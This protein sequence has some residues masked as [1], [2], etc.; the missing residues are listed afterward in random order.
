MLLVSVTK[1]YDALS[2]KVTYTTSVVDESKTVRGDPE[3]CI[4]DLSE[5]IYKGE[6]FLHSVLSIILSKLT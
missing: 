3:T 4:Y 2:N 6:C 1:L 5:F